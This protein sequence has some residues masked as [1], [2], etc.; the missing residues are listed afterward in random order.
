M[1][2][3]LRKMTSN[4]YDEFFKWSRNNHVKELIKDTN[5]SL[6]DALSQTEVE[7]K[8]MLPD[9]INTE[10]NS[11]MVIENVLDNRNVGFMWYLYEETHGVQQVFLCDFVIDELE[12]R[13]GYATEALYVMEQNATEFGCKEC[14]LFVAKENEPAQR[15]YSKNG[16]IFLKEMD[17]GMYLKKKL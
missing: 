16:Y 12:R 5:M 13:K 2:I 4:E 1:S 14:V 11:L 10:N 15:L 3:S 17:Y 6:E 7:V 9:G 8:E